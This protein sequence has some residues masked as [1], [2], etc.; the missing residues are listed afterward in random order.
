VNQFASDVL[1]IGAGPAGLALG[2]YLRRRG[3]DF[4]IAERGAGAGE[5]WR[6]MP[7]TMKLVSPWKS[8]RLP[9]NA[10]RLPANYAMTREEFLRYLQSYAQEQRFPISANVEIV[11]VERRAERWQIKAAETEHTCRLLVNATGYF[12]NPFMPMIPGMEQSRIPHVH[13]ADYRDA[14]H[15]A[16]LI[17]K[18]SGNILIVGKRLSAGQTMLELHDAGFN[19]ALSHRTPIQFGTN[20]LG[21]WFFFRIF[22]Y[23]EWQRLKRFGQRAA[24]TPVLMPGGRMRK[25]IASGQVKTFGEM[26]RFER[27]HLIFGDGESAQFDLVIFATGFRPA[28]SHLQSLPLDTHR[29]TGLPVLEEM[30]SVSVPGLFFIGLDHCRNFQSRFI[31]GIRNDAAFLAD[32]LH[33]RLS[34][35]APA[36]LQREVL[37][38]ANGGGECP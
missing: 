25:L 8:N 38:V 34:A 18:K 14:A 30:E 36:N 15:V 6:R 19:V 23:L 37:T 5:S 4:Q 33:Q 26:R 16:E 2:Y 32:R 17:G 20:E 24:S 3:I 11:S 1:I 7:T 9:G 22:P 12:S 31:R 28:L 13:V 27:E 10:T 29:E 21:W 35:L